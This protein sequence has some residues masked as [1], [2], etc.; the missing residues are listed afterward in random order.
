MAFN[1]GLL[2][3]PS[4]SLVDT[5]RLKY[6]FQFQSWCCFDAYILSAHKR[7]EKITPVLSYW[8]DFEPVG[9]ILIM[10]FRDAVYGFMPP[11]P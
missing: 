1:F 9:L 3:A 7:K 2:G 8:C 10:V 4:H 11:L 5:L 6:M